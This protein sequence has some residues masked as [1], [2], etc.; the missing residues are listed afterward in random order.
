MKKYMFVVVALFIAS[1]SSAQEISRSQVPSVILNNFSTQFPKATDVDWEKVGSQY[2]VDFELDW[3]IDHEVWYNTSG[4]V[5][6]HKK[7][8]SK[9]ALPAKVLS[10]IHTEFKGYKIDDIEEVTIDG[11]ISYEVEIHAPMKKDWNVTLDKKGTILSKV[12]D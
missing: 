11:I 10:A 7:E 3:N 12:S 2:L 1:L 4:E 8:I 6:K 5:V 9:K